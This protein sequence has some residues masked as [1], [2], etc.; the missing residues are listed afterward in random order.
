MFGILEV[1]FSD[2]NTEPKSF[3]RGVVVID[4]LQ[5]GIGVFYINPECA[6]VRSATL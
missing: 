3:Q 5:F 1:F 6:Q 2:L 4:L